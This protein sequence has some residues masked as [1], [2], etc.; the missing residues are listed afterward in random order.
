MF[1]STFLVHNG[2]LLPY[3]LCYSSLMFHS[4][5]ENH[6]CWL[7]SHNKVVPNSSR[8]VDGKKHIEPELQDGRKILTFFS[9]SLLKDKMSRR[10]FGELSKI[11]PF[12]WQTLFRIQTFKLNTTIEVT[13]IM[14]KLRLPFQAIRG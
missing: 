14:H 3:S 9:P 5:S 6:L 4:S 10:G 2:Q 11:L 7:I 12:T 13:L 8:D 1:S